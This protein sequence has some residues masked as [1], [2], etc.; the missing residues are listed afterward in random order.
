M[1]AFGDLNSLP[2]RAGIGLVDGVAVHDHLHLCHSAPQPDK[3]D[4]IVEC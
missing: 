3:H 2:A 1:L 4:D